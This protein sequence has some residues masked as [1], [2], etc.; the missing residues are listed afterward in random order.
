MSNEL[1]DRLVSSPIYQVETKGADLADRFAM[2]LS[3]QYATPEDVTKTPA[4]TSEPKAKPAPT[5]GADPK[6]PDAKSAKPPAKSKEAPK[7][8]DGS[9]K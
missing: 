4:K 9:P 5:K 6:A 8:A 2:E 3:T 1:R 7:P